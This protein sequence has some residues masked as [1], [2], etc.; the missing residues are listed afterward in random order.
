MSAESEV[1]VDNLDAERGRFPRVADVNAAAFPVNLAA[2]RLIDTGNA[3]DQDRFSGAVIAHQ[4]GHL[5]GRHLKVD[6]D[7]GLNCPEACR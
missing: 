1:L 7:K 5:T 2:L 4:C 3:L 6:A